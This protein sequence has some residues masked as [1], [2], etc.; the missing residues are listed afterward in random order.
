MKKRL[1]TLICVMLFLCQNSLYVMAE[2]AS[3][4]RTENKKTTKEQIGR[5]SCRERV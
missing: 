4:I 1:P 2:A 3:V 5:A